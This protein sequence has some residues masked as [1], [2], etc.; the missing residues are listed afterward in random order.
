MDGTRFDALI[1]TLGSVADRRATVRAL[2]GAAIGV[3]AQSNDADAKKKK[4]RKKCKGGKK[5][6]GKKCCPLGQF[7]R[8]GQCSIC[9][10]PLFL[11][12]IGGCA[13]TLCGG[14]C[15][16]VRETCVDNQCMPCPELTDSCGGAVPPCDNG[17][18]FCATS[19]EGGNFCVSASHECGSCTGDDDCDDFEICGTCTSCGG[20]NKACFLTLPE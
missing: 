15:C 14:Q 17:S 10:P 19:V 16:A 13:A 8:S 18:G 6:C 11:C 20:A 2:S 9:A 5:K 4:K 7:C 12:P 1:Q 3:L